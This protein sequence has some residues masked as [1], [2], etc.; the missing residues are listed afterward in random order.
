MLGAWV[1]PCRLELILLLGQGVDDVELVLRTK[2][3][4]QAPAVVAVSSFVST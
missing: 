2:L 3:Q 1:S 4:K